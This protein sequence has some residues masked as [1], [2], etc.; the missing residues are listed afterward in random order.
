[1]RSSSTPSSASTGLCSHWAARRIP[2][3]ASTTAAGSSATGTKRR[4]GACSAPGTALPGLELVESRSFPA[5]AVLAE[6]RTGAA[7]EPGSFVPDEPSE[8]ELERRAKLEG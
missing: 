7:I 1:V 5:A 6:Y 8:A 4:A 3:T 2:A